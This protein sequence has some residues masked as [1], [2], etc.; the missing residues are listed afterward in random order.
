MLQGDLNAVTND[1]G[2]KILSY[3]NVL[4]MDGRTVK[5]HVIYCKRHQY[6]GSVFG[7]VT[8]DF[9]CMMFV[10]EQWAILRAPVE[11]CQQ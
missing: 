11:K 8:C 2:L 5:Y 9:K 4:T 3:W 7:Q 10:L 1:A 6:Q